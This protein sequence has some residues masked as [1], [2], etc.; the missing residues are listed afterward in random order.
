M[1]LAVTI[2]NDDFS[3]KVTLFYP[4]DTTTVGRKIVSM[5]NSVS[6]LS[7]LLFLITIGRNITKQTTM[8]QATR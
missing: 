1:K 7:L 3:R 6:Y 2:P 4:Y 5:V 8:K